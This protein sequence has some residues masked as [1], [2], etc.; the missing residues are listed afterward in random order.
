MVVE[1]DLYSGRPN[2]RFP[3]EPAGIEE[4]TRRI[5]ALAPATDAGRPF[6][7]LGYRGLRVLAGSDDTVAEILV[8][9]GLVTVRAPDGPPR[10]LRDPGR[11]L[12]RW[13]LDQG[14]RSL[15][16]EVVAT[17]RRELR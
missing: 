11:A 10:Q 2:P 17:V 3:L 13:L 8:S 14:T 6:D 5:E 1:V 16:P 9:G 4:L 12:E 15:D 7:G